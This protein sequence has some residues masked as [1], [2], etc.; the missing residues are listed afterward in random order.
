MNEEGSGGASGQ[1]G[2]SPLYMMNMHC[3]KA[4]SYK[5]KYIFSSRPKVRNEQKEDDSDRETG[6]EMTDLGDEMQ[7]LLIKGCIPEGQLPP[8]KVS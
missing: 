3:K 7:C 4:E 6:G 2:G 8:A 1:D 5:S